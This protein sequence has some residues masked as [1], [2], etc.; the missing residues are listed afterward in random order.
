MDKRLILAVA[1]S[2]K[3]TYLIDRL[4]ESRRTLFITYTNTN[5]Q[6]LRQA[7]IRKFN[8]MPRNITVFTYFTFVYSFCYKPLTG[9]S[10]A[11]KGI[12][13]EPNPNRF[14]T[15]DDRFFDSAS[16]I[17][18]NR[19]A[20]L[21]DK[22]NVLGEVIERVEK[23][24]DDIYID[25]VQDFAGNDFNLLKT[26][27]KC[28][29]N[30]LFVGDY[31]QHTYDTSRDGKT[32]G[33]LHDDESKYKGRFK[34]MGLTIDDKTLDKSWRCNPEICTFVEEQLG[35]KIGSHRNGGSQIYVVSDAENIT[36]MA[37]NSRIIKLFF[38]AHYVYNCFSKNWGECKGQDCYDDVCIVMNDKT[39][40]LYQSGQL[41]S[42]PPTTKSKLYVAITRTKANLY[43]IP[44]KLMKQF[45]LQ[46]ASVNVD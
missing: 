12:N 8:G 15:G 11:A 22:K 44:E 13:W 7:I 23:Y 26:L 18:S 32:N 33:T 37:N 29:A 16:R 10:A 17:Y 27:A 41:S 6:N 28:R 9:R 19:I 4:S 25:E 45:K 2:G 30:V 39:W 46:A 43:L 14:A 3:T 34:T 5:E 20:L 42:L 36:K 40:K 1:G 35:I 24:F 21:L 31:F 38:Q